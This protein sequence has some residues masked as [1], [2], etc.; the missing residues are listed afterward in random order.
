MSENAVYLCNDAFM[1]E[2]HA[3]AF[4]YMFVK[5]YTT[6]LYVYAKR[7]D[8]HLSMHMQVY[9]TA[10]I[11]SHL[12][13]VCVSAYVPGPSRFPLSCILKFALRL[14]HWTAA[15]SSKAVSLFFCSHS[16]QDLSLCF[17]LFLFSLF[18]AQLVLSSGLWWCTCIYSIKESMALH[19]G[20][21]Q[22]SLQN[23]NLHTLCV[24]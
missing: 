9:I 2:N 20:T 16:S 19:L 12:G 17:C 4:S 14:F 22:P 15:L 24:L 8:K 6:F 11:I 13:C 7:D 1:R 21:S 18:I 23:T 3:Y 10:W 5:Q